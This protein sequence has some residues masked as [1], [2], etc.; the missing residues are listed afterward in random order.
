MNERGDAENLMSVLQQAMHH[1][2]GKLS[3]EVSLELVEHFVDSSRKIDQILGLAAP[4]NG[5]P[6]RS[7]PVR[8]QLQAP[9][10]QALAAPEKLPQSSGQLSERKPAEGDVFR[11]GQWGKMLHTR[12]HQQR[13]RNGTVVDIPASDRFYPYP[14]HSKK[15]KALNSVKSVSKK[16][17]TTGMHSS[18]A[19]PPDENGISMLGGVPGRLIQMAAMQRTLKDGTVQ[20]QPAH[21][22]W[23]PLGGKDMAKWNAAHADQPARERATLATSSDGQ[24]VERALQG[25]LPEVIAVDLG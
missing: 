25:E 11:D 15:F 14:P 6:V 23:R 19:S 12:A 4:L 5:Q 18:E 20:E 16:P 17:T 7:E 8:E 10:A 22:R 2:D 24:I 1:F 21:I 9:K 13:H 3:R